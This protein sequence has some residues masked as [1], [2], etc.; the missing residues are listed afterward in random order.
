MSERNYQVIIGALVLLLVGGAW[1]F[2]YGKGAD[3][4][5]TNSMSTSTEMT[6]DDGSADVSGEQSSS[7]DTSLTSAVSTSM[8]SGNTAVSQGDM[9]SVSDQSAGMNVT[10]TSVSF[11]QAGWV[12][13]RDSNGYILGAAWFPTG[14]MSDGSI[15]LLRATVAGE[16][17][18][19]L[20]YADDGDKAF[21]FHIDTLITNSDG[22][23]AGTTFTAN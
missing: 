3:M 4:W 14:A 11:S 6:A 17:Y 23:V 5:G 20:M 18:Q 8:P 16:H 10:V 1:Y 12:A 9:V 21:D 15:P 13:V 19:V 7:V 2:V 22:S